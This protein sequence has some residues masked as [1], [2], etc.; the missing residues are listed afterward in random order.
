MSSGSTIIRSKV[1][2]SSL[3]ALFSLCVLATPAFAS[4]ITVSPGQSIQS[5][6][7]NA[8]AGDTIV[9]NAG[10]YNERVSVTRSGASGSPI[11]FQAQGIV[12][13]R[14]FNVTAS[15]IT[16]K[17]F[18]IKDTVYEK[19][20][21]KLGAGVYLN[22]S[23]SLIENNYIQDAVLYGI[24]INNGTKNNT[25][26]N[27]RIFHVGD[28]GINIMGTNHLIE[29]NE[30][31]KVLECHPKLL[32]VEAESDCKWG[33]PLNPD[34]DGMDFFGSGHIIRNNYIHDIVSGSPGINPA[35][36][37]YNN[38]AHT[39]CFQTWNGWAG[40]ASNVLFEGNRC[41][42]MDA[43]AG[44]QLQG[45]SYLTFSHNVV[46]N[47]N[48]VNGFSSG[49]H[50]ITVKNNVFANNTTAGV[51]LV[52]GPNSTVKN[53]IF[54]NQKKYTIILQGDITGT[55][56]DYN[57]A[58]KPGGTA[59]C[60]VGDGYGCLSLSTA[61]N[62]WD[63]NPMFVD[64]ANNDYHLKPGSP[65]CTAGEGG[66]YIGAFPCTAT[67]SPSPSPSAKPG[68]ANNN[69]IVDGV[70]YVIWLNHYKQTLTGG[71]S[72]GDFNTS[73]TVDGVD[74]VLW[75]NNYKK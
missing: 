46:E 69:G 65:A 48:G 63:V 15:Y 61:H 22:G 42:R 29:N 7:N 12:I 30:I 39:D 13:T 26:R 2:V 27:N 49:N 18:Q 24:F 11:T 60:I 54:Y 14:G 21:V 55:V 53:N 62:R 57:M 6:A 59:N 72:V 66:T 64:P 1:I 44:W 67:P 20:N 5:A 40:P 75:L 28:E 38:D 9:V 45:A 32:A 51:E 19:A 50:H 8:N 25:V 10:T 41:L 68:D 31:W 35:E 58:Y 33:D 43:N 34:A 47:P 17:D 71:P 70:D 37:D 52:S 73:G 4:T 3:F 23:N 36:D 56:A 16:I 74:Y